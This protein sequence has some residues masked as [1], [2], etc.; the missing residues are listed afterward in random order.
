MCLHWIL[1]RNSLPIFSS[2]NC[3]KSNTWYRACVWISSSWKEN[4]LWYSALAMLLQLCYWNLAW[5]PQSSKINILLNPFSSS[6]SFQSSCPSS[7]CICYVAKACYL[8]NEEAFFLIPSYSLIW[9]Y[10]F[11]YANRRKQIGKMQVKDYSVLSHFGF[12]MLEHLKL[13]SFASKTA[14]LLFLSHNETLF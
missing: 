10:T 11:P 4:Q 13:S 5:L 6:L 7:E 14:A 8:C 2:E 12:S 1:E 3:S 9:F